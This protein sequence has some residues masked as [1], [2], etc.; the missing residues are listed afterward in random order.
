MQPVSYP[1]TFS[2]VSHLEYWCVGFLTLALL[3]SVLDLAQSY[4]KR[5]SKCHIDL[6]KP[7]L[8]VLIVNSKSF[9]ILIMYNHTLDS[10]KYVCLVQ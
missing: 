1:E 2:V 6:S 4:I 8:L 7:I 9:F 5:F 3:V 10:C